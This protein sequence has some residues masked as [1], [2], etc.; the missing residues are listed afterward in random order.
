MALAVLIYLLCNSSD[1]QKVGVSE[2]FITE[3]RLMLVTSM[4]CCKSHVALTKNK[5]FAAQK[6]AL[7]TKKMKGVLPPQK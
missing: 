1:L 5:G 6:G 3:R 4:T 7:V 2:P